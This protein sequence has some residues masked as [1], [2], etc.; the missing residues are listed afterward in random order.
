MFVAILD[1]NK[2]YVNKTEMAD[3]MLKK[4]RTTKN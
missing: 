1:N 2:M 3:K 4:V